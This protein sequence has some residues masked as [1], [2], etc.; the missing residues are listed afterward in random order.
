MIAKNISE[1]KFSSPN[2]GSIQTPVNILKELLS[3]FRKTQKCKAAILSYLDGKQHFYD[4]YRAT[5][6][7]IA[8]ALGYC[9]ET[10]SKHLNELIDDGLVLAESANWF[11]KDTANKYKLN[12]PKVQ[13]Y[14]NNYR[15]EKTDKDVPNNLHECANEPA[16]Y[17]NNLN[18]CKSNFS[19]KKS[20]KKSK[21]INEELS[22]NVVYEPET[23]TKHE[24]TSEYSNEDKYGAAISNK[25]KLRNNEGSREPYLWETAVGEIEE[26]FVAWWGKLFYVPQGG[27]WAVL[28][29]VP[30]AQAE[31]SKNPAKA[32]LLYKQF[33]AEQN[34]IYENCKQQQVNGSQA[35][36]PSIYI[37]KPD[38]T[39]ENKRQLMQK[40]GEVIVAGVSVVVPHAAPTPSSKTI[41]FEE[42]KS[43]NLIAPFADYDIKTLG[44]NSVEVV[45]R[46]QLVKQVKIAN[47][48]WSRWKKNGD[49]NC[50]RDVK[51]FCEKHSDVELTES[52]VALNGVVLKEEIKK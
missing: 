44:S 14:L 43:S 4:W 42:V 10:I 48:M 2:L 32:K 38:A 25:P 26:I 12:A 37:R 15:C 18:L 20:E 36:L 9:R 46:C 22:E 40:L 31:L 33:M 13:E 52:G 30:C 8:E 45:T 1:N 16:T 29:G 28:D 23:E 39:P 51:R 47:R 34:Q 6:I 3:V 49:K 41:P 11:P 35:T 17:K 5:H 27:K 24:V 7:Q 21:S 19:H 50:L